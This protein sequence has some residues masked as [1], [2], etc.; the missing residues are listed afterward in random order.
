MSSCS[1]KKHSTMNRVIHYFKPGIEEMSGE[2]P[3][4][5]CSFW[6]KKK[7]KKKIPFCV[8]LEWLDLLFLCAV[9]R[10]VLTNLLPRSWAIFSY[11][12]C[13]GVVKFLCTKI[14]WPQLVGAEKRGKSFGQ[15]QPSYTSSVLFISGGNFW[16][17]REKNTR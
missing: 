7:K 12:V 5:F 4:Y 11:N 10:A 6:K 9:R 15:K 1:N 17:K 8:F 14:I 16:R 3:K 2:K 13:M